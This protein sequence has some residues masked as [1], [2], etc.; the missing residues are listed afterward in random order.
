[1]SLAPSSLVSL[2]INEFFKKHYSNFAFHHSPQTLNSVI[3]GLSFTASTTAFI[4]S[5]PIIPFPVCQYHSFPCGFF[6]TVHLYSPPKSSDEIVL[7][8]LSASPSSF[9]PS[10]PI[11]FPFCQWINEILSNFIIF[12]LCNH[13][14]NQVKSM[15]YLFSLLHLM[16]E[17]LLIQFHL[18]STNSI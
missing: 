8:V 6:V 18:L 2:S 7:F 4:P 14:S 13:C 15:N 3:E 17:F 1:M 16:A 12:R 11:W 10:T 9:I 5:T